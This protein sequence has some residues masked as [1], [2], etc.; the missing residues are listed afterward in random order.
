MEKLCSSRNCAQQGQS[1][2][3][4]CIGLTI[5]LGTIG[6][7]LQ[8]YKIVQSTVNKLT[9]NL[10]IMHN[11]Q[12]ARYSLSKDVLQSGF[13]GCRSNQD[14]FPKFNYVKYTPEYPVIGV[15][16]AYAN[17]G[18]KYFSSAITSLLHNRKIKPGSDILII[19]QVPETIGFLM[20]PMANQKSDLVM[21]LI[22]KPVVGDILK[23]TD[24]FSLDR[25]VVTH[26]YH[27]S[28]GHAVPE[29]KSSSFSKAYLA[30][31]LVFRSSTVFYYLRQSIAN[32]GYA[33]YREDERGSIA[34]A[35]NIDSMQA[36]Y[37]GNLLKIKLLFNQG[38]LV[39]ITLAV[40]NAHYM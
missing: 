32:S 28:I 35:E 23:I 27:N 16:A 22:N 34:I 26:V 6:Y 31:N 29:N 18:N 37:Q 13:Q 25:F 9:R 8:F 7:S 15:C 17:A 36:I 24:C 1:L 12:L 5:A 4:I 40:R 20:Q 3:A 33:L 14:I 30:G 21:N 11:V 39:N 10:N 19:G 38:I 2:I